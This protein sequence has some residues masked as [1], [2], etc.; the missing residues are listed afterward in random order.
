MFGQ[1][2]WIQ[3]RVKNVGTVASRDFIVRVY[4]THFAGSQFQ[5]PDDYTPSP[6][7]GDPIP[8]PLIQGTYLVGEQWGTSLAAGQD[9]I[10]TFLWEEA[11]VPPTVVGGTVWHPCLL[12]EVS[13]AHRHRTLR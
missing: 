6:N 1:D 12:A 2:N 7:R 10:F 13:P 9:E 5:Y 11:L 8:S 3:L 4:L